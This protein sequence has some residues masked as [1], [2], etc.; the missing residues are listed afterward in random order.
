MSANELAY[1]AELIL[2]NLPLKQRRFVEE[3]LKSANGADAYK[4]AGYKTKNN[5]VAS[6]CAYDL[7][8][9]PDIANALDLLR[10]SRSIRSQITADRVLEEVA[11]IAFAD[12]GDIIMIDGHGRPRIRPSSE[13]TDDARRSIQSVEIRASGEFAEVIKVKQHDKNAALF[14]L[15]EHLGIARPKGDGDESQLLGFLLNQL[16]KATTANDQSKSGSPT[17]AGGSTQAAE[18][19]SSPVPG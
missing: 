11:R 13:L 7:L 3:Y 1:Q 4:R 6:R 15:M 19:A 9:K 18:S 16:S 14:K 10:R 12:I 17:I 2:S 5:E 8:K